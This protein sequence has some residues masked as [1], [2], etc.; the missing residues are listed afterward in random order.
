MDQMG[1]PYKEMEAQGIICPVLTASCNYRL[2]TYFGD[3][4]T[5]APSIKAYNGIRLVL[6]Y[7]V[8]DRG[9]RRPKGRRGD[10][11]LLSEPG[12]EADFLKK[13]RR[14][15]T[16]SFRRYAPEKKKIKRIFY[17]ITPIFPV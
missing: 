10:K 14:R 8:R 11:P 15:Q 1:I 3:T 17:G 7:E 2:M 6:S 13:K 12:G 16:P 5:I 9:N 4:V